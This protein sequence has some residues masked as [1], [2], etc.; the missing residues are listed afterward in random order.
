MRGSNLNL[1]EHIRPGAICADFTI[2]MIYQNA[3]AGVNYLPS[4]ILNSQCEKYIS[5]RSVIF[6]QGMASPA[7]ASSMRVEVGV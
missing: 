5:R 2:I 7:A 4:H 1:P 3:F 6:S